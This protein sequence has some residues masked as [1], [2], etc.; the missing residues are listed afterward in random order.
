[1]GKIY[2]GQNYKVELTLEENITDAQSLKI[3]YKNPDGVVSEWT[4]S[5]VDA[6]KGIIKY[7]VLAAA[8]TMAGK[9]TVWAKI[10][11]VGGLIFIG[12]PSSY[13]IYKQG[14]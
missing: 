8:N 1:M 11:D 4:A 14:N 5:V 9:F 7:D 13:T 6:L 3:M 12:Q 10:T 2:V